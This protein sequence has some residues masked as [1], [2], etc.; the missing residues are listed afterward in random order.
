LRFAYCRLLRVGMFSA[1][2]MRFRR[3]SMIAVVVRGG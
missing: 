3:K 2:G 1:E